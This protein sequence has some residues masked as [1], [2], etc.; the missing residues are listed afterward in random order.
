MRVIAMAPWSDWPNGMIL[1]GTMAVSMCGLRTSF[2][3]RS[4]DM[5][6]GL[7]Q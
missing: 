1:M 7:A 5:L 3:D 2:T 4:Q 6:D